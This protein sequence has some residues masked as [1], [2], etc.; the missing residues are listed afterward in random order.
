ML[1]CVSGIGLIGYIPSACQ[2][3]VE[4]LFPARE[5]VTA[6]IFFVSANLFSQIFSKI[7]SLNDLENNGLTII[8]SA[9]MLPL[10]YLIFCYET[11]FK[12][13]TFNQKKSTTEKLEF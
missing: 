2:S 12:R 8:P 1:L 13:Y 10:L 5:L 4:N 11:E 6:T 7:A 3:L 9:M